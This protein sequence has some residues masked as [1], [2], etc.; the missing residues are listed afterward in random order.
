VRAIQIRNGAQG[1]RRRCTE[2][3][4]SARLA[5]GARASPASPRWPP[6]PRPQL[7]ER[8]PFPVRALQAQPHPPS[9]VR[10]AGCGLVK[11]KGW[12]VRPSSQGAN[13][14]HDPTPPPV[15]ADPY[16]PRVPMAW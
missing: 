5:Y 11:A 12:R 4:Q 9:R 14:Q 15:P 6:H 16:R 8:P 2:R 10:R 7:R 1:S 3:V 13:N